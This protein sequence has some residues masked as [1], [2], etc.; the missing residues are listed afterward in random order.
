MSTGVFFRGAAF[1][2]CLLLGTSVAGA[3]RV[4]DPL[5]RLISLRLIAVSLADAL[6][7]VERAGEVRVSFSS[8]LLP[9]H[10][11]VSLEREHTTV[12]AALRDILRGTELGLVV[13][14][15]GHIV[16]LHAPLVRSAPP[17]GDGQRGAGEPSASASQ[18]MDRVLV[19]GTPAA[20]APERELTTAVTVVSRDAIGSSGAAGMAEQFRASVPG[21]VAWNLGQAGPVAQV[22]SVRGSS[23]FSAN[24]LKTYLDGV[25]LA[26]PY[27]LFAVD[28][29][30]L[31]RIEVIRGP[32]GSA[33]YGSDAISGV[34]HLVSNKGTIGERG[35]PRLDASLSGGPVASE[36]VAR[37]ART[38]HHTVQL[39]G[40]SGLTAWQA[41]GTLTDGGAW[42]TG[43]H[44][45]SASVLTSGRAIA[46][47]VLLEATVRATA[48]D[49]NA[50]VSPQLMSV[51]GTRAAPRLVAAATDQRLRIATWGFTAVHEVTQAWKQTLIVGYDRNWGALAP[52]RNA[53]TV[54]DALLGASAEDARRFSVRYGTS[55]RLSPS[56]EVQ[57]TIT[58][59]VEYSHLDRER[60]GTS[61][62]INGDPAAAAATR[63]VAL[64]A[65][66]IDNAGAFEQLKVEVGTG[67]VL[68]GGLRG[69]HNSTFGTG[70][71]T[72]WSPML[73]A[74]LVRDIGRVS[75]KL[76]AAYGRGIRPPPPSA[77]RALATREYRQLP[78]SALAPEAQSGVEAGAELY[79]SRVVSLSFTAFDQQADGLI[80]HVLP[81][82]RTAPRSVQLQN[83][84]RISNRGMELAGELHWAVLS[85]EASFATVASRVE[86]LSP[87]YTGDLRVGDDVPEVPDWSGAASVTARVRRL[88]AFVGA[89]WLGP[90]TGYDWL[91][92]YRA[93]AAGEPAPALRDH[94]LL[95]RARVR[96][97]L[98]L[99]QQVSDRLDWFTRVD[100]VTNEQHDTRDNLQVAPGRTVWVGVRFATR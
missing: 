39:S 92:Y 18:Q 67:L 35:P 83:V 88:S 86:A 60:S 94:W 71:G 58:A 97:Q 74:S 80:Q 20:G 68:V 75:A 62:V 61:D 17:A 87:S 56:S 91:G 53:A 89:T 50:P 22:G 96:P 37:P 73:G 78:N 65:D 95:Y 31:D 26:S 10:G 41:S 4:A 5:E 16:I 54:A 79:F 15:T 70:C 64:Y 13:A 30:L 66:T 77:R 9:A 24:Y 81:S 57:S 99:S 25:E 100:N 8:D 93:L 3:Q 63:S 42:V 45:R 21:V 48:L 33:L 46:G 14:G 34:A 23:S 7:A 19:M 1:A 82:P 2:T 59:G 38:Q 28:P 69:E 43:L 52:Q 55:L 98:S 72:A 51:L 32:Q 6:R 44:S 29:A 49:F 90:W 40:A 12:G 47:P 85:A 76:R 27:L 84:G 11:T 36:F